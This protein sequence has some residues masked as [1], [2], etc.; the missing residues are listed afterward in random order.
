MALPDQAEQM[1]GLRTQQVLMHET[2]IARY[3][4][5]FEGSKVIEK[6]TAEIGERARAIA[7]R[8]RE[9]GYARAIALVSAELTRLLT[10]RQ[11]MIEAGEILQ[12]GVNAF[13]GE[14]GLTPARRRR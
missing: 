4:D 13:I 1:I 12:V 7:M 8:L 6:L 14:I 5:I 10:E 3:G 11:R 9:A 2:G